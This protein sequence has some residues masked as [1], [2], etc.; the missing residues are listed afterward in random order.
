M[1]C[2]VLLVLAVQLSH[3]VADDRCHFVAELLRQLLHKLHA[4]PSARLLVR[5]LQIVLD[6]LLGVVLELV[7]IFLRQRNVRQDQN[8]EQQGKIRLDEF[9]EVRQ[10]CAL[11]NVLHKRKDKSFCLTGC[12]NS[13]FRNHLPDGLEKRVLVGLEVLS[14][15]ELIQL[16]KPHNHCLGAVYFFPV[17]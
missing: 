1:L 3:E 16:H 4:V 13:V 12:C 9:C 2:L 5:L 15:F 7:D 8:L 10:V 11:A 6:V 14:K 17:L